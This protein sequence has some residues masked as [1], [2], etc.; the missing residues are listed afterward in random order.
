LYARDVTL[1]GMMLKRSLLLSFLPQYLQTYSLGNLFSDRVVITFPNSKLKIMKALAVVIASLSFSQG[2]IPAS[3]NHDNSLM[4]R[5]VVAET[6][7]AV[8]VASAAFPI[9]LVVVGIAASVMKAE[10][11]AKLNGTKDGETFLEK[12]LSKRITKS[13]GSIDSKKKVIKSVAIPKSTEP[14]PDV[15]SEDPKAK[16]SSFLSKFFPPKVSSKKNETEATQS[17][18]V[19]KATESTPKTESSQISDQTSKLEIETP[20]KE[21]VEVISEAPPE[22]IMEIPAEPS[23]EE[24]S[25]PSLEVS[26]EPSIEI[27]SEPVSIIDFSELKSGIAST[28]EEENIKMERLQKSIEEEETVEVVESTAEEDTEELEIVV[29]EA[30]TKTKKRGVVR[31]TFRVLKKTVAPWR[32]WK[33]I[34]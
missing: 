18:V 4:R 29:D 26:P 7:A 20:A 3:Q 1:V 5:Y 31:F 28:L 21:A 33:N 23:V 27:P 11:D 6:E 14:K 12:I 22:P 10:E 32:K 9:T 8:Q 30:S 17:V 19:P 2:F 24:P 16:A 34:S 25:K 13:A 15:K